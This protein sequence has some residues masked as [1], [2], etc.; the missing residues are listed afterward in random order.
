MP[1]ILY[2]LNLC[3]YE[4]NVVWIFLS[5]SCINYVFK[6]NCTILTKIYTKQIFNVEI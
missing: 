1:F 5:V 6:V 2:A 4:I 3:F